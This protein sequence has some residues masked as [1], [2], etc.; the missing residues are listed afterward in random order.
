MGEKGICTDFSRDLQG[1]CN[2]VIFSTQRR[3]VSLY[4]R[5]LFGEP[6]IQ[7]IEGIISLALVI[8][9][10]KIP[11]ICGQLISDKFAFLTQDIPCVS[12][13]SHPQAIEA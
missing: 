3:R 4:F 6:Q 7:Q 13:E 12:H 11:K 10:P 8:E 2:E 1:R 9:I 5:F